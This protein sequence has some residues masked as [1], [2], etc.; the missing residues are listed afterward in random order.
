MK[1][2]ITGS[3]GFIGSSLKNF[4]EGKG[5]KVVPYDLKD[6]PS[7]DIRDFS[8]L[9]SKM[10]G[11]DGVVHL[12]AVSRVKLAYENPLECIRTN[13]GGTINVLQA[14]RE[15]EPHPWIIFASS[16]EVYGQS[17]V[18]PVTEKTP[19]NPINVYGVSKFTGEKLCKN[20]SN[21]Y[22]LKSRVLRFSNVYSGKNDQ[23]DRVVPK[24]IIRAANNEDLIINGTGRELFD[25]TYIKDTVQGIWGCLEEV[26]RN[27]NLY[28]D[29]IL[30]SGHPISLK[31]LAEIIIKITGSKSKIQYAPARSYDVSNFYAEPKK[32]REVLGFKPLTDLKK[33]IGLVLEEFR[34]EKLI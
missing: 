27:N 1:I 11:V 19:I 25:F 18:L 15:I 23:L 6:N 26:R 21:H 24:F 29:F 32:A 8:N 14:A 12:A 7:N 33:G 4:V 13:V 22:G 5:I 20:F 28:D 3:S 17:D 2:L 10:K 16:R 9:K 30:S 34:R 31:E